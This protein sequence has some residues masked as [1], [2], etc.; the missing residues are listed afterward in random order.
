MCLHKFLNG[1][2]D[3]D[4]DDANL[5]VN[6]LFVMTVWGVLVTP[7]SHASLFFLFRR[8]RPKILKNSC[9]ISLKATRTLDILTSILKM[10]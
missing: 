2:D 9:L 1:D 7:P 10:S 6:V 8:Q 5:N 3:D 4:D